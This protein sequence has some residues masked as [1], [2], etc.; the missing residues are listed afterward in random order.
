[1]ATSVFPILNLDKF[2]PPK[3]YKNHF[4]EGEI[5]RVTITWWQ[6]AFPSIL[7]ANCHPKQAGLQQVEV[8]K[9][10]AWIIR[11]IGPSLFKGGAEYLM[12][13]ESCIGFLISVYLCQ[14]S[15][16]VAHLF[17]T[18]TQIC[19]FQDLLR[20]LGCRED[21]KV[22]S[23]VYPYFKKRMHGRGSAPSLC[24]I[25]QA[26]LQVWIV[27]WRSMG[28]APRHAFASSPKLSPQQIERCRQSLSVGCRANSAGAKDNKYCKLPLIELCH[29]RRMN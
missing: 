23:V 13:C 22:V 17:L 20:F 27:P 26:H 24:M 14:G 16:Y 9:S 28:G 2:P 18:S 6:M 8:R 1:M 5:N 10:N 11:H 15:F 12:Q 29:H 7:M 4:V 19:F 25:I 21:H 3:N